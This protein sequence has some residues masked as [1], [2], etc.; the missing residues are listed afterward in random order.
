MSPKCKKHIFLK[1]KS[2]LIASTFECGSEKFEEWV[3][4][5]DAALPGHTEV[6]W[7]YSGGRANMLY[8]GNRDAVAK[9][10]QELISE[11]PADIMGYASDT[12]LEPFRAGV[13]PAP[14]NAMVVMDGGFICSRTNEKDL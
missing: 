7:H 11:C 8:V 13:S 3:Q 1:G 4:K 2:F 5:V 14:E 10:V 9:A 6:D 12:G